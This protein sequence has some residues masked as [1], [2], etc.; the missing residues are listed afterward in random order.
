MT[1][2]ELLEAPA[3]LHVT[4]KFDNSCVI[5]ISASS[6]AALKN[7]TL[8]VRI[9]QHGGAS[10]ISNAKIIL[11]SASGNINVFIGAHDSY[12]ALGENTS[13]AFDLRLWRQST[14]TVAENTTSNGVRIVC[15]M[16]E[17]SIGQDCM[18]SDGILV[19]SADQH[20]IVD[21]QS[22]RIINNIMRRTRIADHVWLGRHSTL[23]PDIS[24]GHGSIIGA[25]AIVTKDIPETSVAVG[26]PARVVKTKTTWSRSPVS[27][28][29]MA[30]KY[31]DL[32]R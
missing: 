2:F 11:S 30:K 21:L 13:G 23:L 1:E 8:K 6:M 28:D 31:V 20:G 16:S 14:I 18:F 12:L 17:V 22:G 7:G 4:G 3:K 10:H 24:I 15:D 5:S 29:G 9:S 25:G 26:V 27:L 19:Q 32:Y